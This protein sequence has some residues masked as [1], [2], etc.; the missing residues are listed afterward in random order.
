MIR[1]PL[2]LRA[3][4]P[5][6]SSTPAAAAAVAATR[7]LSTRQCLS[8]SA[9]RRSTPTS[10]PAGTPPHLTLPRRALHTSRS[11]SAPKRDFYETLNVPKSASE[12]D[13]KRAYYQL[14]KKYHPDTSSEPNAKEKFVEIQQAYD[15]LSDTSK[16]QMYDSMGHAAF[17][18]SMGGPGAGGAGGPTGGAGGFGGF[19]AGGFTDPNDIL[20]QMFGGM[21][22]GAGRRGGGAGGARDPFGAAARGPEDIETE[23]RISF[24][25]AV[26]GCQKPL[27]LAL[28]VQCSPCTGSGLKPGTKVSTCRACHGSG[29]QVFY[30]AGFQIQ[31]TCRVCSGTGKSVPAGSACNE[32]HGAGQVQRSK[33]IMV[34]VPAGV[35]DGMKVRLSGKGD[36]DASGRAGDLYVRLKV[37]PS[38]VFTR[39]DMD[40][41]VAAKVPLRTALLGGVVKV[42]TIDGEVELKVP[43]GTQP[44][45]KKLLRNRGVV[46][47][48]KPS[49]RG[50]QVVELKVEIPKNI[51]SDLKDKLRAILD[52]LDGIKPAPASE[53]KDKQNSSSNSKASSSD[54]ETK[55][56]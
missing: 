37:M 56:Q 47:V 6:L 22:G 43:E 17:D 2:C 13:I 42:P 28:N 45:E 4:S 31:S 26:H 41:L 49:L 24:D 8:T 23:L 9:S 29:T 16:R 7:S 30:Q 15:V 20:N 52:E 1:S 38:A 48:N 50:D 36:E 5:A 21:F 54:A 53:S 27:R 25:D 34:D 10:T 33:T 46:N 44:G 39:R 18:P 3:S 12:K 51:D 19:G 35:D 55:K 40:I 32:C 11:H 14:A